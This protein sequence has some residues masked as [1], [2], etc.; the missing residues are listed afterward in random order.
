MQVLGRSAV[1]EST[2]GWTLPS[3]SHRGR[4]HALGVKSGPSWWPG[5]A[6]A[7]SP[8][9]H[10][11]HADP[12]P[13]LQRL[14]CLASGP[15][16]RCPLCL[17][18]SPYLL[19]CSSNSTSSGKPSPPASPTGFPAA[20]IQHVCPSGPF[21]SASQGPASQEATPGHRRLWDVGSTLPLGFCPHSPSSA[22]RRAPGRSR[23]VRGAGR[24][25]WL[26]TVQP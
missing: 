16:P 6:T 11:P 17:A 20:S 10:R 13:P 12:S 1:G 23:G 21:P 19:G 14:C 7:C 8:G 25:C 2:E 15:L 5:Q 3:L 9:A 24:G 22:A 18:S 4:P 26:P